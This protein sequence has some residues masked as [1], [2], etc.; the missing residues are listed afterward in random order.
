MST[1]AATASRN[2]AILLMIG[3]T[4]CFSMMDVFAKSLA[5]RIG[6][7]AG[8]WARYAGQMLFV[9]LLV[10]PRLHIVA[11]TRHPVQQI[12]RS[13]MLM[14]T[15][16]FFFTGLTLLPLNAAAPL[17][18]TSPVLI[19]LG[20]ALFLGEKL[21]PRR[22]AGIAAAMV[23]A[24]IV[25][26]PGSGIFSAA[27]ALPLLA[28]CCYSAYALLTRRLGP[29]EDPWTSL[30]YTGVVGTVVFSL[31]VPFYWQRPDLIAWLLILGLSLG[32]TL[33]Q[34]LLIRAFSSGEA[35]MLAPYAYSGLIFA[36]F[37]GMTVFGEYP[38]V[39]TIV[40]T[41]VIAGAGLYVW[42]RETYRS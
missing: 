39:W 28:A 11:R 35:A 1:E 31:V 23:G 13:F 38:D 41:L 36:S 8:L 14:G 12:L 40:G 15:T 33:G 6:V 24:L 4:L 2:R 34:M 18:N 32:G 16:I 20:A 27:A 29:G 9:V 7:P 5:P 30:F 17:M 25:I 19:T 3:A 42:H 10:A 22:I 21:G 37:W 26:R